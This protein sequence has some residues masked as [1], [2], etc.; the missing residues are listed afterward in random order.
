MSKRNTRPRE[1]T[2]T[3]P[4]ERRP[5]PGPAADPE[6]RGLREEGAERQSLMEVMTHFNTMFCYFNCLLD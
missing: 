1:P 3:Q 6:G 4:G 5:S 2:P